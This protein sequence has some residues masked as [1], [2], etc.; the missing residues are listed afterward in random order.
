MV[1]LGESSVTVMES[2]GECVVIGG[3]LWC[4]FELITSL[5]ELMRSSDEL[6]MS[7][8]CLIRRDCLSGLCCGLLLTALGRSIPHFG[9]DL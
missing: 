3:V 2:F 8:H 4:D 6:M 5:D 9:C 1:L 7:W